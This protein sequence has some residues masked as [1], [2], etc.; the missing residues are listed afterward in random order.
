MTDLIVN[1]SLS[2]PK[3]TARRE[4]R[5]KLCKRLQKWAQELGCCCRAGGSDDV[6]AEYGFDDMVKREMPGVMKEGGGS[7]T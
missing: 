6:E 1:M 3:H 4:N 2:K 7:H 5:P